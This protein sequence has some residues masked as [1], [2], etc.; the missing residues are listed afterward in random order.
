MTIEGSASAMPNPAFRKS[1]G[2]GHAAIDLKDPDFHSRPDQYQLLKQLRDNDPIYWNPEVG[3]PGFWAVTRFDDVEAVTRARDI[4]STDY[5]RGGMRIFDAKNVT[6]NPRPDI[7]AIDPPDHTTF[8]KAFQPVF[9]AEAVATFKD[10]ARQRIRRLIAGIGPRGRAEFVSEIANP[11]AAGLLTDLLE[12][13]E[14]DGTTLMTWSNAMI[15]DDDDDYVPSIDYRIQCVRALDRYVEALIK[16]R[17]GS[18]RTDFLTVVTR[19]TID[20]KPLDLDALCENFAS[21]V[22]A[23]NETTRHTMTRSIVA[24]TEN[25]SE[26][27]KLQADPA[28]VPQAT[29]EFVRWA[30]PLIHAR[31]TATRDTVLAGQNIREGDKVVLWYKSANRDDSRWPDAMQFKVDRYCSKDA[32]NHISF[33]SGINHCLGWRYAEMQITIL[34]EELLATLPDIHAIDAPKL[35]RS[36]FI[37]GIKALDVAFTPVDRPA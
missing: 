19:L 33:G 11:V 5:R 29:K 22:V 4:F 26:R 21:F 36:N 6:A 10:R 35:L 18:D 32:P 2:D 28:L 25:P 12:V 37:A 9:S 24:L 16:E 34:F 31:R 1:V 17:A 3:G 14:A 8:R 13:P 27:A 23:A 15:G 20:N 7:F 30:T